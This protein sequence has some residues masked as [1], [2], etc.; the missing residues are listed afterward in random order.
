MTINTAAAIATVSQALNSLNSFLC[1]RAPKFPCPALARTLEALVLRDLV[2]KAEVKA[3][4]EVF[5]GSDETF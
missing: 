5:G 1:V 2:P 3:A 4:G